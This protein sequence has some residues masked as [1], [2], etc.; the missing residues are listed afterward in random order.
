MGASNSIMDNQTNLF[1]QTKNLGDRLSHEQIM[2]NI[3]DL[4]KNNSSNTFSATTDDVAKKQLEE[5]KINIS[6]DDKNFK[7]L[8][9]SNKLVTNPP[10]YNVFE[11]KI[12]QKGG[13]KIKRFS[14]RNRYQIYEKNLNNF[15]QNGGKLEDLDSDSIKI[16]DM[17]EY[18]KIR[19]MLIE[20]IKKNGNMN[21]LDRPIVG[22][23]LTNNFDKIFEGNLPDSSIT[24]IQ[25]NGLKTF[26]KALNGGGERTSDDEDF[27]DDEDDDLLDDDDFEEEV[28]EDEEEEVDEEEDDK[29]KKDKNKNN[30]IQENKKKASNKATS[31]RL[32]NNNYSETSFNSRSSEINILPFFSTSSM[33]DYSFQRP[34]VRNR[35][36]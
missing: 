11:N 22:G 28:D 23:D 24:E 12:D 3:N 17:E 15:I 4:F 18:D 1:G 33:S 7:N 14:T 20:D 32:I 27:A 21:E 6:S 26:M 16:T 25:S 13:N 29:E 5:Q 9:E 10:T 30:K 35:F 34:Y 2:K 19:M 8:F 31:K 36:V